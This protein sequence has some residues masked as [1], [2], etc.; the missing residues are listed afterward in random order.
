MIN[1]HPT[2]WKLTGEGYMMFFKF[3][4]EYLL[5]NGYLTKADEDSFIGGASCIIIANY[6]TSP[7]GP[8][9]ELLFL[10]GKVKYQ[11]KK[12]YTVSKAYVSSEAS[13]ECGINHWGIPKEMASFNIIKKDNDLEYI[14]VTHNHEL[15]LDIAIKASGVAF[16]LN[17]LFL[18][19]QIRQEHD[20]HTYLTKIK[21]KGWGK[22]AQNLKV[23]VNPK[24]FPHFA[25]YKHLSI[26][27]V[28]NFNLKLPVAKVK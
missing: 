1:N 16:P 24:L 17:S 25:F 8:Y 15:I 7:V 2:S 4:K 18:P 28:S 12:M 27:H 6:Q 3:P 23:D 11:G 9:C 22:M 10:P 19:N 14:K 21:G 13:C 26:I 5:E 20:E